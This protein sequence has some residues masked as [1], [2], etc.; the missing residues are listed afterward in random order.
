[1]TETGGEDGHTLRLVLAHI[2]E[3]SCL[4]A[5]LGSVYVHLAMLLA[6]LSG[7]C[8]TKGATCIRSC[9]VN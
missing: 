6:V 1:M 9:V 5:L 7:V 3:R 8:P 4:Q 2:A